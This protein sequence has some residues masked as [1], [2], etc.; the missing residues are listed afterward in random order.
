MRK[1]RKRALQLLL[2]AITG[3]VAGLAVFTISQVTGRNL[4]LIIGAI[5]G[6]AAVLTL[7]RYWGA[8]QLTEVTITVPQVSELKFVVNNEARLVAW[9]LY[10]ETVTRV[11]TQPLS[12]D[13]GF[14]REALTS[15]Y[16]LFATTRDTLKASRPSIPAA[17]GQTV[18]HLAVTML[19]RQLRPFLSKWHPQLLEFEQLHP[20]SH[21][22]AWPDN[23][24]CRNDLRQVQENLVEYALGFARLAG[25]HDAKDAIR[26]IDA[27]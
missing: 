19:N 16:G 20:D 10:I 27:R 22:T 5:A 9:Q 17:G 11:A 21:E 6:V 8:A 4:Y 7:H 13:D 15:L 23:N 1:I 25:V 24:K 2:A 14:L 12:D 26:A 18:E 3:T